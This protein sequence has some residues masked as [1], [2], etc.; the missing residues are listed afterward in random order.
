MLMGQ[1]Y[2]AWVIIQEAKRHLEDETDEEVENAFEAFIDAYFEDTDFEFLYDDSYDGI[3]KTELA[4]IMSIS[5]LA[6]KDWFSPFS[7]EPS[8]TPHPYVLE[9]DLPRN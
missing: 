1:A 9:D 6:F 3:E 5:S 4:Q 8:R 2:T 7:N